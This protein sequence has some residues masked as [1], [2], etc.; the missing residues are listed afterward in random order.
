MWEYN[1]QVQ[2]EKQ[3]VPYK[4]MVKL[5]SE[6]LPEIIATTPKNRNGFTGY[7]SPEHL[8]VAAASICLSTTFL[9]IAQNSNL[10]IEKFRVESKAI[11]DSVETDGM[12]RTVI[13][14]IHERFYLQLTDSKFEKKAKR[15]VEKAIENCII[16]N[17]VKSKV[18][19]ELILE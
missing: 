3:E 15:V 19:T 7:W 6:G 13:T 2:W 9:H 14:E 8:F 18:T 16:A 10:K 17:S 11:A 1:I 5:T 12:N 4:R